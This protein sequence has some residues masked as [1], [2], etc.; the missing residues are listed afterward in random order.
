MMPST[1]GVVYYG[2]IHENHGAYRSAGMWF[3]N[4]GAISRG[5]L[6]ESTLKRAPG[7]TLYD[8]ERWSASYRMLTARESVGSGRRHGIRMGTDFSGTAPDLSLDD[9]AKLEHTDSLL[10]KSLD[11]LSASDSTLATDVTTLPVSDHLTS[12]KVVTRTT[13]S[14]SGPKV[15]TSMQ[16]DLPVRTATSS[17]MSTPTSDEMGEAEHVVSVSVKPS[18]HAAGWHGPFQRIEVPHLPAKEVFRLTEKQAADEKKQSL[19][20]FLQAVGST[21]LSGLSL[22]EVVSRAQS[23]GLSPTAVRTVVECCERSVSQ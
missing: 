19:D 12:G 6:H 17:R 20:N 4:Q 3:C 11:D 9:L 7:V 15:E 21:T 5:S 22:E 14:T 18:G 8:S 2:H 13:N 10:S 1:S 16:A 23:A